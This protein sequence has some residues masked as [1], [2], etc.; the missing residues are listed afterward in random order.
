MMN[1][2]GHERNVQAEQ[3]PN[4]RNLGLSKSSQRPIREPLGSGSGCFIMSKGG[5]HAFEHSDVG[6]DRTT[7]K[8]H[9]LGA[10][11]GTVQLLDGEEVILNQSPSKYPKVLAEHNCALGM[12]NGRKYNG[13]A[14]LNLLTPWSRDI[15]DGTLSGLESNEAPD[16]ADR[17][18]GLRHRECYAKETWN[19]QAKDEL[20]YFF[21]NFP[22]GESNGWEKTPKVEIGIWAMGVEYEASEELRFVVSGRSKS[23]STFCSNGAVNKKGA[24]KIDYGVNIRAL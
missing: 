17:I 7:L 18:Q 3:M 19:Q 24:Y 8:W 13:I 22:K 12:R 16:P 5:P 21:D 14:S 9:D 4:L 10:H 23:V 11:A 15:P 20:M 2:P 1:I 6:I